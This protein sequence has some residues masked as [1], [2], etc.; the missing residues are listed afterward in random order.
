MR[1]VSTSCHPSLCAKGSQIIPFSLWK[2]EFQLTWRVKASIWY[3]NGHF[4]IVPPANL[5]WTLFQSVFWLLFL[6]TVRVFLCVAMFCHEFPSQ[7]DFQCLYQQWSALRSEETLTSS[8]KV[9]FYWGAFPDLYLIFIA[10]ICLILLHFIEVP[11]LVFLLTLLGFYA[12]L[13]YYCT[14]ARSLMFPWSLAYK[15]V[16]YRSSVKTLGAQIIMAPQVS[17]VF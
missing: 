3:I 12:L 8:W 14:S 7:H 4:V 15:N 13:Y 5:S 16:D 9:Y 17:A 6:C 11:L 1:A 2:L 10:C